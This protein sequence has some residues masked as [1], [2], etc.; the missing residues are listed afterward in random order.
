MRLRYVRDLVHVG[1]MILSQDLLVGKHIDPSPRF[2]FTVGV[3]SS[4]LSVLSLPVSM[5]RQGSESYRSCTQELS[6]IETRA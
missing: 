5:T 1:M 2:V 6:Q 3:F 4:P